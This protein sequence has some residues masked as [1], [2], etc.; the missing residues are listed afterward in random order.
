MYSLKIDKEH[1][2]LFMKLKG[3]IDDKEAQEFEKE[4]DQK[5]QQLKEGFTVINDI[6]EYKISTSD[7]SDSMVR[8]HQDLA[9]NGVGRVIRI[10]GGATGKLQLQRTARM[11]GA[12]EPIEVSTMEEALIVMNQPTIHSES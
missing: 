3:L 1:N 4:T 6:T 11:S 10:T 7:A 5:S 2:I 12:Y 8:V 9:K